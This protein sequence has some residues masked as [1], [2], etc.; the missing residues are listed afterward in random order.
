MKKF[1]MMAVL[2]AAFLMVFSFST[3]AYASGGEET[4]EVTE[5]PATSETNP[6]TPAGTGTVVNTATDED[7][8]QFYTITTPDE[9]VF[10]LVIDLQRE[11]DNVYFLNAVTEKDLL[12]LAEKSEDTVE[13]E[14]AAISTPEPESGSETDISSETS[15]ETSAE[16]EQKSNTTML[17][18][19]LAVVVIGGGAGYYFKIYRPKQEQ[20]A[21]AEDEFDEYETN[22]Y[23]EQEDDTPPWEVDGEDSDTG[24][25]EDA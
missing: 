1:R 14:T 18:L 19:V 12:A 8:K 16:L 10:Y 17:L 7:S 25:D 5:A 11:M 23:D 22:P 2:C 20:A 4:P 13:N 9:N 21:L 15:L 3:V 24:E 6:F